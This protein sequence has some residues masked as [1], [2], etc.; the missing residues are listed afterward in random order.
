MATTNLNDL[1]ELVT[2]VRDRNSREYI[3]EAVSAYRARA[4]RAAITSAWIAVTYDIIAKIRELALQSDAAAKAFVVRLEKVTTAYSRGDPQSIQSMQTM[5]NSLLHDALNTFAFLTHQEYRDL[6]RLKEDRNLCAHPAFTDAELL[7]EPTPEQ[8]R[9]HLVHAILHLLSQR[10]I[11][12][13]SALDRLKVDLKLATFPTAE[14]GVR[15]YLDSKY[16]SVAKDSFTNNV[17][18][19]LLVLLLRSSEPDLVGKEANILRCLGAFRDLRFTVY[20]SK[21]EGFSQLC[22]SLSDAE[23]KRIAILFDFDPACWDWCGPAVQERLKQV[24]RSYRLE[25]SDDDY[26]FSGLAIE[27]LRPELMAIV[28]ALDEHQKIEIISRVPRAE[29]VDQAITLYANATSWRGAEAR[30]ER[31]VLPLAHHFRAPHIRRIANAVIENVEIGTAHGTSAQIA[32][33]FEKTSAVREEA[34]NEW[35]R[36]R[37]K[38]QDANCWGSFRQLADALDE[39]GI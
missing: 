27:D 3:A 17:V 1:D 36:L 29:F 33:L 28:D 34:M 2:N 22:E 19:F 31:L 37:A 32:Q 11:Q 12:G 4:Y 6:D 8:V 13:K 7:F 16:L 21:M 9:A 35:Q 30:A 5:E 24:I 25:S 14:D 38:L 23:L 15:T 39:A 10:P 18:P 26:I 20:R